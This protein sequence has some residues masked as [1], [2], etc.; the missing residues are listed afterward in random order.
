VRLLIK[1]EK[2]APLQAAISQWL[3][4]LKLPNQ[5]RLAVDIDPQSFY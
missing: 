1:A 2:T 4:Q 5:A 3:G